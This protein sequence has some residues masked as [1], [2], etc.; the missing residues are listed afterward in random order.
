MSA[1]GPSIFTRIVH[2]EIPCHRVYE[3]E[4]V[5][6]FL[7][8]GPLAPGH[9]LLIPKT[10]YRTLDQVPPDTA[11]ALGAALPKLVAAVQQATGSAGVN[12]LQNNGQV[13]GQEVLHVH[14]HIIPRAEGDG[15][16]Y[17]WQPK[18]Y[19][20]GKAEQM[21]DKLIALLAK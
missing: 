15:L 21:R 8:I 1:D 2:G 18:S 17:R 19:A 11:A 9:L 20:E 7:D 10:E 13:A 16:G 4:H 6:A 14:F 12:I 3:D 5:L